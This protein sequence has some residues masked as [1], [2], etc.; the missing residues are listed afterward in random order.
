MGW[1]VGARLT[2]NYLF[3]K[4][5]NSLKRKGGFTTSSTQRY[6]IAPHPILYRLRLWPKKRVAIIIEG[7]GEE[8]II[9][10]ASPIDIKETQ[11][12]PPNTQIPLQRP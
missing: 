10:V 1:Q 12:T 3:E 2:E 11:I 5:L 9:A 4:S 7:S 6:N 8:K